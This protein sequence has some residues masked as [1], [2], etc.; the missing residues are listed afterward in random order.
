MQSQTY[1]SGIIMYAKTQVAYYAQK[2][3]WKGLAA[4]PQPWTEAQY[5]CRAWT[6]LLYAVQQG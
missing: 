1:Y 6:R 5:Y 3:W 2:K 4:D